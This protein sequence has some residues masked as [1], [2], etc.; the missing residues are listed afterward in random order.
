MRPVYSTL[1]FCLAVIFALSLTACREKSIHEILWPEHH[2]PYFQITEEWSRKGVVRPRLETAVSFVALLKS[3]PWREAYVARHAEFQGFTPQEKEKMLADQLRAGSEGLDLI[4]A[5][6]ATIPEHARLT[7]RTSSWRI[8]LLTQDGQTVM[9]LEIRPLRWS[10]LELQA[11]FPAY[12]QWQ[13][14]YS[15]RFPAGQTAPL[16]LVITGPAGRTTLVWD[17]FE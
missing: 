8:F 12:Q 17:S 5:S 6:A 1:L 14:Y 11:Y 10:A 3:T 13:R 9:P 16:S 2:D 15:L 4:L 7:H